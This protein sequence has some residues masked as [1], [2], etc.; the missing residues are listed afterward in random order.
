[1]NQLLLVYNNTWSIANIYYWI[2][3]FLFSQPL[4]TGFG[5]DLG[6][7]T[8]IV[9]WYNRKTN[10]HNVRRYVFFQIHID[11]NKYIFWL[12]TGTIFNLKV[13]DNMIIESALKTYY[14]SSLPVM[15]QAL[16]AKLTVPT[17]LLSL[18]NF[19]TLQPYPR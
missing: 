5:G 11:V 8:I 14:N 19:S 12:E 1:M 6:G 7:N 9:H 15:I 3:I 17:V 10:L 4:H 16:Q 2:S 18:S 13:W